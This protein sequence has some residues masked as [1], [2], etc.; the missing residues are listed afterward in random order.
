[1]ATVDTV[2]AQLDELA[3]PK[4]LHVNERHGDDHAVNLTKL[5]AIAK[6]IKTDPILA[7]E[8]WAT[9]DSAA[10]LVAILISKPKDYT[11]TE[12]D[13]MLRSART[14]KVHDW[15]V[16]Y[17]VSKS[18]QLEELRLVWLADPDPVIAS[19]GWDLTAHR[20]NKKPE[21]L[22]LPGLLDTIE[23]QMKDAPDRLQWAMNTCLAQIGIAHPS[24]RERAIAIGEKLEVLKDYPTP[25]N[26][27]S[28]YA[29]IWIAEIVRRQEE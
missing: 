7:R 3:D 15:L 10:K 19:A 28:P 20:V 16:G 2:L 5:R 24:L 25:P 27:T 11:A 13:A 8:L 6:A 9:D 21:G 14:R 4:I 18:P 26:C 1:M 29:P 17:I 22:D 12:L 23:Q